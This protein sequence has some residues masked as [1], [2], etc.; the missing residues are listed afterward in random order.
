MV[1]ND[2]ETNNK[3][4]SSAGGVIDL[5]QN[6]TL[7]INLDELGIYKITWI[8]HSKVTFTYN[9]LNWE[10]ILVIEILVTNEWVHNIRWKLFSKRIISC[11]LAAKTLQNCSLNN[12][13]HN[14]LCY[15]S[16]IFSVKLVSTP[17]N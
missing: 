15:I 16:D 8:N 2:C 11:H 17:P 6:N 5:C 9:E 1:T 7:E 4:M 12:A 3:Y 14:G 13:D 10:D